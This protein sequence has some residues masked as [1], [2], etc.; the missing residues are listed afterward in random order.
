MIEPLPDQSPS[1]GEVPIEA[2]VFDTFGTVCDFYHP[3]KHA[4]E[5]LARR[6]DVECDAGRMAIEWRTAYVVST[7]T[8]AV[9]ESEFRPLRDIN[10]DNLVE[11]LEKQFPCS[12][13]GSEISTLN[14]IWEKLD[15]WPDAV[16]PGS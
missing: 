2:V 1:R 4:F 13:T 16:A 7:L 12:L 3:M 6:M 5:A 15:P 11:V 8:Q 9:N 10:R 14:G